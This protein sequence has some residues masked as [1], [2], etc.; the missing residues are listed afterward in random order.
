MAKAAK[1]TTRKTTAKKPT[2]ARTTSTARK[3]TARKTV[4]KSA[5]KS[6]PTQEQIRERAFE[7]YLRRNGGPG[8][9]HSDWVQAER[10]LA[11]EARK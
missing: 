5:A 3:P 7:I 11:E 9:A 4:T 8:D 10:E 1:K 2:P 6:V